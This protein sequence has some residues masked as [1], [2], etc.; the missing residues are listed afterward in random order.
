MQL[1][2]I[3]CVLML[4]L[5]VGC[6]GSMSEV[7]YVYKT[8]DSDPMVSRVRVEKAR[9]QAPQGDKGVIYSYRLVGQEVPKGDD[10]FFKAYRSRYGFETKTSELKRK[11]LLDTAVEMTFLDGVPVYRFVIT[12]QRNVDRQ[13]IAAWGDWVRVSVLAQ[14]GSGRDKYVDLYAPLPEGERL[15]N[16]QVVTP[17]VSCESCFG[18]YGGSAIRGNSDD[19]QYMRNYEKI[20]RSFLSSA[21]SRN[22]V[23][24]RL[25]SIRFPT[26]KASGFPQDIAVGIDAAE[27]ARLKTVARLEAYRTHVARAKQ[28]NW[29]YSRF[30]ASKYKPLTM[31]AFM[32]KHDCGGYNGDA[33]INQNAEY[34]YGLID[35]NQRYIRCVKQAVERYNFAAYTS[36]YPQLREREAE[37]GEKTYGIERQKILSAEGQLNYARDSINAAYNGIESIAGYANYKEQQYARDQRQKQVWNNSLAQFQKDWNARMV[38]MNNERVV[39]RPDGIISTV[40]EERERAAEIART[41]AL[42]DKARPA[43]PEAGAEPVAPK[44]LQESSVSVAAMVDDDS[45]KTADSAADDSGAGS[46]EVK[47]E[48]D[49]D[50]ETNK[51]AQAEK[52]AEKER[53]EAEM[54]RK[55]EE[56]QQRQEAQVQ[57]IA[58]REAELKRQM[59]EKRRASIQPISG[60]MRGCVDL[61]DIKRY[62]GKSP[63]SSCSYDEPERY[64]T[65]FL[66]RNNCN[67]PVNIVVEIDY[68]RGISR[69]GTEYDVRPGK[70]SRSVAYCGL[71]DYSFTY[72]E[73]GSSV[74]RRREK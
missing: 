4:A 64:S 68:D 1:V 42:L 60:G 62:P 27:A 41:Q 52:L 25:L 43:K 48:A 29:A 22:S 6:A 73:T 69:Q 50:P 12:P 63:L 24:K 46:L 45:G 53:E 15:Q 7:G 55:N 19:E 47:P 18:G 51:Q 40:G 23:V 33:N 44:Q 74:R 39:V 61:L 66:F 17:W 9:Q 16:G 10:A 58:D 56:L 35:E 65:E 28:G 3:I 70:K 34:N 32:K 13:R 5:V 31:A 36:I 21:S 11:G 38:T 72:E 14:W 2:R 59:E 67:V 49:P 37:L 8:L 71:A 54:R 30:I 20:S 26:E 57:A